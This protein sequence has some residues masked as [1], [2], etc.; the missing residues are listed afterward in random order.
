G[1]DA[2]QRRLA[3]YND[4]MA[5]LRVLPGV[6]AVGATTGFPLIGGGSDGAYMIMTRAD[7]PLVMADMPKLLKDKTRSG[8]ANFLIV[9][10]DYFEAMG[11]PLV[12]GRL[13]NQGD[14]PD[15]PHA[16]VVSASLAKQKW[17]NESAIGKIIQYGNM[18][19]D[20]RPFTVVGVVGDVRDRALAGEPEPTFY[21]YRRQRIKAGA[22]FHIVMQPSGAPTSVIASSRAI[23]REMRPE[24]VPVL[25]TIETIVSTSVADRRFVLMLVGVF[26][27]AAL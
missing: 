25:R 17:P 3:F 26:G 16:A 14:T 13:F 4:L 24:A 22:N 10:G 15:A 18:D 12:A 20:L 6:Q 23:V 7:E 1:P 2:P 21:G 5:R 27:A 9:G 19:G 11:I 8:Y